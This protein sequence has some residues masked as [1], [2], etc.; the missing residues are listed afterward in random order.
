MSVYERYSIERGAAERRLDAER[1]LQALRA[2]KAELEKKVEYLNADHGIEAEI[3]Q[4]F[5]VAR[6]G[7]QVVIIVD[8][9]SQAAAVAAPSESEGEVGFWSRLI[10]W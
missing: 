5:D 1:E 10:P 8:G 6:A 7:E 4:H 3:R 9:E 2:Q